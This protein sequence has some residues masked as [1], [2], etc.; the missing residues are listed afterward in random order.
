MLLQCTTDFSKLRRSLPLAAGPR[1]AET[2]SDRML[3]LLPRRHPRQVLTAD[4]NGERRL[5]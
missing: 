5:L 2:C 3:S 4:S 1:L